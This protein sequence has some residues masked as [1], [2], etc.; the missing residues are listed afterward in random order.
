MRG[1]AENDTNWI[2][3]NKQSSSGTLINRQMRQ[4]D[5]WLSVIVSLNIS[6]IKPKLT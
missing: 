3:F 5:T 2:H 1:K 6:H 4:N